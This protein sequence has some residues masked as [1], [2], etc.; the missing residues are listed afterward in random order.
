MSKVEQLLQSLNAF[1]QKA[2]EEDDEKLTDVV[3]D[4]PGLE[5]LPKIV[6]D[7]E[8]KIAKLLR[9]QRK[10]YLKEMKAFV[11]KDDKPTLEAILQY[12]TNNLFATD[13]FAEEFG[14]VTAEFL[15][16][17]IEE[18]C[19]KLMESIDPDI[20]FVETSTQTTNWVKD[21]STKLADLMQLNTHKAIEKVLTDAIENGDSIQDVEL[22][23]KDLPEFDRKRARTT[24]ITEILTA[25]SR[26]Q[27][28]SYM[29]SPAV[30]KKKWK[31]SG[32]KKNQPR[33]NHVAM[34]GVEV[35]VDEEFKIEGSGETCQYPRDPSL[36]AKERVN[37]HCTMGPVVDESILG[38]SQEEKEQLRQEALKELN[39]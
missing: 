12:F 11:S 13:E 29:Q 8:K 35:G 36:S 21:W 19:K 9:N 2:E 25:S 7:Y 5:I 22:K 33:E 31:H 37:C 39:S 28:E 15:Q 23:M 1:I 18:L 32:S 10:L 30:V 26:A 38:L 17:T 34:D 27:W 20:P 4:F 14:E 16:L 6:E 24:A 3:P